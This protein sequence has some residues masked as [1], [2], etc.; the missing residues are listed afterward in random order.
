M[1]HEGWGRVTRRNALALFPWLFLVTAPPGCSPAGPK[2]Y[3]AAGTPD[4]LRKM[5]GLRGTG[6][7]RRHG[8]RA[9]TP[10]RNGP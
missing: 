5:R 6:D 4:R 7:P 1:C 9:S 10:A 8:S 3:T 2:S